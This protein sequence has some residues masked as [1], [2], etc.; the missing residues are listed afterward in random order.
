MTEKLRFTGEY[1]PF[2][3]WHDYPNWE[4]ALEEECVEGQD[5]TT[6]RP[7]DV[8]DHIG[9]YV[10]HTVGEVKLADGT[11]LPALLYVFV[12]PVSEVHGFVKENEAWLLRFN[13]PEPKWIVYVDDWLPA[14]ERSLT[15][16]FEDI[17]VFPLTVT[18][19]LPRELDGSV[20]QFV[21]N[22]DGSMSGAN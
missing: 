13:A 7:A 14:D 11:I 21:I 15:I 1:P 12:G 3:Y 6:L 17:N 20:I 22:P 4:Y 2:R 10:S 19:R 5:E 8:Q 9:Q 18:S 16:S